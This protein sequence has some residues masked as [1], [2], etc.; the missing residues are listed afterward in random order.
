MP[1]C[2]RACVMLNGGESWSLTKSAEFHLGVHA[3]ARGARRRRFCNRD[4][5]ALHEAQISITPST[6]KTLAP[7]ALSPRLSLPSSA[8]KI[9]GP[10]GKFTSA[11]S[12]LH[13]KG[14]RGGGRPRFLTVQISIALFNY[15]FENARI[16]DVFN[17]DRSIQRG[18]S[19]S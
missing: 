2:V 13:E 3:S 8:P 12:V 1:E 5:R 9:R 6:N 10:R 18:S 19:H 11:S 15:N 14:G 4:H 16:P 7:A 17:S